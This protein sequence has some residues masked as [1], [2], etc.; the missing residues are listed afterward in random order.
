MKNYH[1][2]VRIKLVFTPFFQCNHQALTKHELCD[3]NI[4]F[5]YF[6][7]WLCNVI[8]YIQMG[9]FLS[10]FWYVR[11]T[12][13]KWLDVITYR[14]KVRFNST[15]MDILCSDAWRSFKYIKRKDN[16]LDHVRKILKTEVDIICLNNLFT[17]ASIDPI[18]IPKRNFSLKP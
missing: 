17:V 8:Y 6:Y 9:D 13:F 2:W 16:I 18:T 14:W 5:L 12:S 15:R 10:L 7:L 1:S 4:F 11:L 3:S